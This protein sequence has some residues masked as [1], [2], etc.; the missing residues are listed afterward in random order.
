LG[1]TSDNCQANV[2]DC[3]RT[4]ARNLIRSGTPERVTM[5]LTG[6]PPLLLLNRRFS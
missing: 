3:L 1:N 5:Q 4:A 2:H 6:L